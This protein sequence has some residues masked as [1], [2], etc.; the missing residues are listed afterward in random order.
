MLEA[1]RG[2]PALD[3][4]FVLGLAGCRDLLVPNTAAAAA[5]AWWWWWWAEGWWA[6]WNP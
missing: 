1:Q 2:L 5:A 4:D 3:L 6:G